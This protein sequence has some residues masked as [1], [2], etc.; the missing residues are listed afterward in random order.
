[1][2]LSLLSW[3]P[4]AN[5]Q[6]RPGVTQCVTRS[7]TETVTSHALWAQHLD[8]QSQAHHDC[9]SGYCWLVC[10]IRCKIILTQTWALLV[11]FEER[12]GYGWN[13]TKILRLPKRAYL[14]QRC[15]RIWVPASQGR[16]QQHNIRNT[17]IKPAQAAWK[18]KFEYTSGTNMHL[19]Q[20]Q[21][22]CCGLKTQPNWP[23]Y[24][25]F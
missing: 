22:L 17:R 19:W 3:V 5:V 2:E 4:V 16:Q 6:E 8:G 9:A 21:N 1:M 11:F 23:F 20:P 25:S 7:V 12:L 18:L 10:C 15:T 24:I 14:S 13:T